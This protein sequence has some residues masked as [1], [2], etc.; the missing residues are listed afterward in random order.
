[1]L[2]RAKQWKMSFIHCFLAANVKKALTQMTFTFDAKRMVKILLD[3]TIAT[4]IITSC[5]IEG[6][7]ANPIANPC[8]RADVRLHIGFRLMKKRQF[9]LRNG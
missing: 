2:L 5:F 7:V 4:V 1:M 6:I 8:V 3:A 9:I